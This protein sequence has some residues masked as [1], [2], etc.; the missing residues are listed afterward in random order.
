MTPSPQPFPRPSAAPARQ[1]GEPGHRP[2][3]TPARCQLHQLTAPGGGGVV[4]VVI[5]LPPAL[6]AL[7]HPARSGRAMPAR[8]PS[9][10]VNPPQPECSRQRPAGRARQGP[11]PGLPCNRTPT[12]R[13]SPVPAQRGCV[14]GSP[15]TST[16]SKLP[17]QEDGEGARE[18]TPGPCHAHCRNL[19]L[20]GKK[21]QPT[22]PLVT[23]PGGGGQAR[24]SGCTARI[25]P[26]PP[27]RP[28]SQ[29]GDGAAA[30]Q[31]QEQGPDPAQVGAVEGRGGPP[32]QQHLLPPL[33]QHTTRLPQDA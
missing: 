4:V 29:A 16:G 7:Y 17:W 5:F 28:P 1:A 32:T 23:Q 25:C 19:G 3:T 14:G 30:A 26:Y 27:Q 24:Q 33:P 9:L 18:D 2:H 15:P 22:S 6:P 8:P 31:R 12:P 10:A 21:G 20:S 13:A 11:Q